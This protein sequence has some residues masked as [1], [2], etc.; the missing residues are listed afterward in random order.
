MRTSFSFIDEAE[1]TA[2]ISSSRREDLATNFDLLDDFLAELQPTMVELGNLARE[3]TPL[4]VDLRAAAPGLNKLGKNLPRFNNASQVSL[5]SLGSASEVG[6]RALT[7]ARDEI[8]ALDTAGQK[9]FPAVDQV[10]EFLE[11]VDDPRNAVEEDCDAR[12]DLREQPGEADRRQA[13]L[14][15]KIGSALTGNRN[16]NPGCTI[17]GGTPGSGNPGYT[18]LE[19]LLN[20]A[21][22]QTGSLNLFDAAGH[23]LQ[24]F[25]VGASNESEGDGQCGHYAPGPTWPRAAMFGGGNTSNPR[26]AAHCVAILGDY[27]P[28]ISAGTVSTNPATEGLTQFNPGG[29]FAPGSP[30]LLRRYDG[31]VCPDGSERSTICDPAIFN[32]ASSRSRA[33][34]PPPTANQEASPEEPTEEE[35]E[36]AL[37]D[38]GDK[39]IKDLD[40]IRDAL[41]LP[42]GAPL[43]P[44]PPGVTDGLGLSGDASARTNNGEVAADFLNFLL[45]P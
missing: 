22:V 21:Y 3:Q 23:A 41:G 42:P 5:K 25:I 1:D 9:A 14:E 36:D 13:L 33:I 44:L 4:L 20:Y 35:V 16:A 7:K 19:G 39:P 6:D 29:G 45:G 2:R 32:S 30:G 11:S 28:G 15:Q 31:S 18:G 24:I 8:D 43:P 12:Y 37:E 27:Q 34:G 38:L 17:G 26:E 10:A 40:E